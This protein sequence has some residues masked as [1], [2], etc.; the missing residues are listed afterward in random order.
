MGLVMLTVIGVV[1]ACSICRCVGIRRM[2]PVVKPD[3]GESAE[4]TC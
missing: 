2:R 1:V 3:K 4:Y